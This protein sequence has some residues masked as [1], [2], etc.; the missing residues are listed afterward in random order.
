LTVRESGPGILINREDLDGMFYTNS[1]VNLREVYDGTSS[2]MMIGETLFSHRVSGPDATGVFQIVDHWYIGSSA[3]AHNEMSESMGSTAARIN[4][5]FRREAYIEDKELGYASY[6]R[7]GAQVVFA[8]NHTRMVSDSID[9]AVW[10]AMG[11]R[12]NG[13]TARQ[14]V[15]E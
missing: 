15:G 5:F 10:S 13:D 9:M 2:T 8:D 1:S 7:G 12:E 11:T 6:H 4:S 3:H 14:L